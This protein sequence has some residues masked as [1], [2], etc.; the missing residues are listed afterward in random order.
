MGG[1]TDGHVK[2]IKAME[3]NMHNQKVLVFAIDH[4]ARVSLIISFFY[5]IFYVSFALSNLVSYES[6]PG[7]VFHDDKYKNGGFS[8]AI[9]GMESKYKPRLYLLQ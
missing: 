4:L 7:R 8:N 5:H 6:L 1:R 9:E 2:H 3:K